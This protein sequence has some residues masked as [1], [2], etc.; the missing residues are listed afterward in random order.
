MSPVVYTYRDELRMRLF[1][2]DQRLTHCISLCVGHEVCTVSA[3][4]GIKSV[5]APRIRHYSFLVW[6][7]KI[8]HR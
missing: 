4:V 2:V 3:F 5:R 6:C 7:D 8:R 1:A